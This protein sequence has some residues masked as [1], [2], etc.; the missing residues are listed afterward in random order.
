[1][2]VHSPKC[3]IGAAAGC[4][5]RLRARGIGPLHCWIL[6]GPAGI[7]VRRLNNAATLNG[8]NFDE[9]PLK[10]GDRLRIG[11]VE[12]ELVEC[13][14]PPF[15]P[16]PPQPTA[17]AAQREI[18]ALTA[19]H[20]AEIAKL[21][22]E[23]SESLERAARLETEVRQGFE[24]SI[25]AAERADQLRDALVEA[26]EQLEN[27]SRELTTAQQTI[28]HQASELEAQKGEVEELRNLV[29][30]GAAQERARLEV[31]AEQARATFDRE[32]ERWQAELAQLQRRLDARE[33]ELASLRGMADDQAKCSSHNLT[34]AQSTIARQASELEAH[35]RNLNNF[36]E[37]ALSASQER[38][39][40]EE[41]LEEARTLLAREE[42]RWKEDLS[43]LQRRLQQRDAELAAIRSG[44]AGHTSP[45][46]E[47]LGDGVVNAPQVHQELQARCAELEQQLA[48]ANEHQARCTQLDQQLNEQQTRYAELER[49]LANANDQI[50]PLRRLVGEYTIIEGRFE[51]LTRDFDQKCIELEQLR[52]QL[53]EAQAGAAT[54][55]E[56]EER[57]ESLGR[58]QKE[59]ASREE[60]VVV[61]QQRLEE[62]WAAAR[63]Q[64]EELTEQRR[65]FET[66]RRAYQS[67]QQELDSTRL[68]LDAQRKELAE[69]EARLAEER[70][71]SASQRDEMT[72]SEAASHDMDEREL[73]LQRQAE[74][75][76]QQIAKANARLAEVEQLREQLAEE[77]AA[78]DDRSHQLQRLQHEIAAKGEALDERFAQ[79][80]VLQKQLEAR[81]RTEFKAGKGP[82]PAVAAIDNIP[83]T[84]PESESPAAPPAAEPVNVTAPWQP[85]QRP[86]AVSDSDDVYTS[87]VSQAIAQHL[88]FVEEAQAAAANQVEPADVDS[89]LSRLV[90]SGVW[91]GAEQSASGEQSAAAAVADGDVPLPTGTADLAQGSPT[92][93]PSD[94]PANDIRPR[95]GKDGEEESIESYMDRLLKR[96]RGDGPAV[97]SPLAAAQPPAPSP[98]ATDMSAA[99]EKSQEESE[100]YSPRRTAPE[101]PTNLS[102]MRD[103]A[104]SA[105]RSAIDRH[106]RKHTGRQA[107]GKLFT[108]LLTVAA[109]CLLSYWAW[110]TF[111]LQ[112]AVGAGIGG[113]AG[114]YWMMAA[115]RRLTGAIRLNQPQ[116]E[117]NPPP[118]VTAK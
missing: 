38:A 79:L 63:A 67:K 98:P 10:A 110:K 107:A 44:G 89:V 27:S 78:L 82:P 61:E 23:L 91:R 76:G 52:G 16:P 60:Q 99:D 8:A 24:S 96:V 47:V 72:K 33:S 71:R 106:V 13:N 32:K 4:T 58:W 45:M 6:R 86:S 92:A 103:L 62:A 113:L 5:L 30:A 42:D 87:R 22:A 37:Q 34:V 21:R 15:T 12:L 73:R 46:T 26:D 48:N 88:S 53:N 40:L 102:A 108:A 29:S 2:H 112:A 43:R 35:Q 18:S 111:S 97:A 20:E 49:Q 94:Q 17:A 109:S 95:S 19:A 104:N 100:E 81:A 25:M 57:A 59:L 65:Q 115:I 93:P 64:S 116:T 66:E 14:Q 36:S 31:E 117:A 56:A 1:M 101:L 85:I 51:K 84:E 114:V 54:G 55:K 7:V 75:L 69:E 105:A 70:A 74:E 41:E 118:E 90:R 80:E 68:E 11:S 28:C 39:R 50:E 3:T 83:E 9:A 77:R